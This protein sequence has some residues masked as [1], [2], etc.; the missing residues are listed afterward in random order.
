M[1][2]KL[3]G[4]LKKDG[5]T[6]Q[7][8]DTIDLSEAELDAQPWLCEG[9]AEKRAAEQREKRRAAND[10]A[11]ADRKAKAEAAHQSKSPNENKE[12]E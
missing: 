10:A 7:K 4:R 9:Y 2:V 8:G 12:E 5:K 3:T 1:K 6:Y 11:K